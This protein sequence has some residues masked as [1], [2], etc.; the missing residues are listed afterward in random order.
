M[1]AKSRKDECK[2]RCKPI[3]RLKTRGVTSQEPPRRLTEANAI[4]CSLNVQHLRVRRRKSLPRGLQKTDVLV[5]IEGCY[6][7]KP[8]YKLTVCLVV[9]LGQVQPSNQADPVPWKSLTFHFLECTGCGIGRAKWKHN[10]WQCLLPPGSNM[11]ILDLRICRFFLP[12]DSFIWAVHF[13]ASLML[14]PMKPSK[15][16]KRRSG[17][18]RG[19][20]WI[21]GI[22][23]RMS[24]PWFSLWTS[25]ELV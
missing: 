2:K 14:R 15:N 18:Y 12:C 3:S 6:V 8:G 11:T 21:A 7:L 19:L 23:D 4:M 5:T 10:Q 25:V 1:V 16:I 9:Q 24:S 22:D 13:T 17:V 20:S